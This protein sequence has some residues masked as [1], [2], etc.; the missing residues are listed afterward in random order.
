MH[1]AAN[2][3]VFCT[4]LHSHALPLYRCTLCSQSVE[5]CLS[6]SLPYAVCGCALVG[7]DDMHCVVASFLVTKPKKVHGYHWSSQL[8]TSWNQLLCSGTRQPSGH[9]ATTQCMSSSPTR[10]QPHTAY[11]KEGL[12]H[13]S[14]D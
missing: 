6:P 11:G 14:T 4:A 13:A 9:Q 8:G 7:D 12:K 2:R 1:R 3:V 10:A 5:A